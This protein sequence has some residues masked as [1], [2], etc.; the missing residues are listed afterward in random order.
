MEPL[1]TLTI[2]LQ[3]ISPLV[4]SG[5]EW[6]LIALGV[7]HV[8]LFLLLMFWLPKQKNVDPILRLAGLIGAFFIPVIGP[9]AV[10]LLAQRKN[11]A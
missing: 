5:F 8:S 3:T 1:S 9:P 6:F 7:L 4:P 2:P 10:W 11:Q